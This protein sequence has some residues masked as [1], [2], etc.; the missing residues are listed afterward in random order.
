M[1]RRL[2]KITP[3]EW[4]LIA[5]LVSAMI[6]WPLLVFPSSIITLFYFLAKTGRKQRSLGISI[7][8]TV[9]ALLAIIIFSCVYFGP[10]AYLTLQLNQQIQP[11]NTFWFIFLMVYRIF[12]MFIF[13]VLCYISAYFLTILDIG[14]YLLPPVFLI[15]AVLLMMFSAFLSQG[16][17]SG[18]VTVFLSA[19]V[20]A[21]LVFFSKQEIKEQFVLEGKSI[22]INVFHYIYGLLGFFSLCFFWARLQELQYFYNP[23]KGLLEMKFVGLGFFFAVVYLLSSSLLFR[24]N[25]WGYR[26]PVLILPLA[27][28]WGGEILFIPLLIGHIVFFN[29]PHVRGQFRRISL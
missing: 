21:H 15:F 8:R 7:F 19:L 3:I 9:Y 5:L 25:A 10:Q 17:F 14:G 20:I 22:G 1:I 13:P 28:G 24:L 11:Q 29:L 12:F 6:F 26:L 2:A 4:T 27:I 16:L 18:P 23:G